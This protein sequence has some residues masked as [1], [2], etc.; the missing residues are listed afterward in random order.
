MGNNGADDI[1]AA[2]LGEFRKLP[3]KRRP[4]VRD[5]G[6]RE[7]V[8][9][10]GIVVKG[11]NFLKCVALA[12]GMKCLPASKLPHANGVALHDWH[13]EVLAIRAFNRFILDECGRLAQD[14]SAESE[15]LRR[16]TQDEM[17]IS[18]DGFWNRQPF[19]WREDLTLHMYCSEAPCGDASMELIMSS[20]E[21]ATPWGTPVPITPSPPPPQQSPSPSTSPAPPSP[22]PSPT[23]STPIPPP[24]TQTQPQ[25]QPPPP[26]LLGRGYFSHLGIVRR[27]PSRGDA[28]PSHSKSC[29]DK[30]ALKQCTSL[31]S[32]LASLFVS[33]RG[34]YL[35]SLVLP[36]SQF[37]AAG[38]TRCFAAEAAVAFME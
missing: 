24:Q 23:P 16:R 4:A 29:S 34:A 12:T 26:T 15:F 9:L 17:S 18:S 10:S 31:L 28:P 20:Q 19:A 27:K 8:P 37:S 5:N 35:A 11:P 22:S 33:P 21:D 36:A 30:L 14:S 38:C 25:T 6:L 2:V 32:S 3:A 1:A 7:W 13:A